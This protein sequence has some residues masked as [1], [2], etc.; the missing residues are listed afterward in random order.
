MIERDIC[1]IWKWFSFRLVLDAIRG[2]VANPRETD[3]D[4]SFSFFFFSKRF[5]TLHRAGEMKTIK[6]GAQWLGSVKSRSFR[7]HVSHRETH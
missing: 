4:F 1:D 3:L 5:T 6:R 2:L 7:V